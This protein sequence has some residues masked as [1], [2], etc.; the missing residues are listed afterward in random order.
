MDPSQVWIRHLKAEVFFCF[1]VEPDAVTIWL[2]V[3]SQS[4]DWIQI[5]A[6]LWSFY[7]AADTSEC[8]C[9]V[10]FSALMRV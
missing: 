10:Y 1:E 9:C 2:T 5:S 3:F 4:S 7:F 8:G 6:A